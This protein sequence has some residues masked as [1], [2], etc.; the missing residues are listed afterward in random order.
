MDTRQTVIQEELIR[1]D[2]WGHLHHEDMAIAIVEFMFVCQILSTD[3]TLGGGV[4]KRRRR[5]RSKE[6]IERRSHVR[7]TAN[8]I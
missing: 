4:R 5:R 7:A 8:T 2:E 1:A 3:L 6:K